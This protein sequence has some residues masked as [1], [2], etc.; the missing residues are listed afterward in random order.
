MK[1]ALIQAIQAVQKK[2]KKIEVF[3]ATIMEWGKN[4]VTAQVM[5][6]VNNVVEGYTEY[7]KTVYIKSDG[8]IEISE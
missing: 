2:Y 3:E 5:F 1:N 7:K 8:S 4:E 6:S